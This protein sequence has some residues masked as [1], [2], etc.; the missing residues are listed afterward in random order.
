MDY[1]NNLDGNDKN[2]VIYG[3]NMKDNS[4]FG[5]LSKVLNKEWRSNKDNLII[6]LYRLDGL[7][8][9]KVFSTYIVLSEEYYIKTSFNSDIDYNNFLNTIKSRSNYDYNE[10]LNTNSKILTLSTCYRNTNKRVVLH[11]YEI[12]I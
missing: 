7:H 8:L 9:Y 3:H 11:A 10:Y 12:D 4:M 5:K 1:R 2:I 6:K